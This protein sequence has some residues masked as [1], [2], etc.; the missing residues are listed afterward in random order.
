MSGHRVLVMI[1]KETYNSKEC[2]FLNMQNVSL[3]LL[4]QETKK[5]NIEKLRYFKCVTKLLKGWDVKTVFIVF[6]LLY[7]LHTI[8]IA[9]LR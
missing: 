9:N 1:L 3:I 8:H 5:Q 7:C 2:E 6:K 4:Y